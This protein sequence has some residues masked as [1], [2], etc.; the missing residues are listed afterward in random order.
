MPTR[1]VAISTTDGESA[2]TLHL[3]SGEG[4]WPAVIVYPDAGG[5]RDTFREMADRLAELG[6]LA[7]LPDVYYRV[8][9][10]APFRMETVLPIPRNALG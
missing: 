7:L 2:A 6:Y 10:Y 3:P 1:E 4:A 8:G 9:G 5:A